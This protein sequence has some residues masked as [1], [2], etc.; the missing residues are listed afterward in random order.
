MFWVVNNMA[1]Q[2]HINVL[3]LLAI[4]F[5]TNVNSSI[6]ETKTHAGSKPHLVMVLQDDLGH[7]DVGFNN[8]Q[9]SSLTP[10]IDN[11]AKSG[12]ILTNHLVHFHCSPTRRSFI[13]GRLP[14]HHGEM[15]SGVATDDVDLRWNLISDKMHS[16]GYECHWIGKGHTGYKSYHHLPTQRGFDSFTGFLAGSQ[17]YTSTDRWQNL[18][19][20]NGSVYSSE[21]FGMETINRIEQR[22]QTKPF[23]LYL[24]WQ[25]VHSPYD[26]VPGWYCNSC[27]KFLPYPGVYAGMLNSSDYYF[28][29]VIQKFKSSN[30]W[31]NMLLVYSSDNG[32]VSENG[33]AGINYP[34]RG[35]KHSNWNGGFRVAAFVS[36]GLIPTNLRG[37]TSN[38]RL[39]IV[40]W[41][42]TFAIMAGVSPRDDPPIKPLPVDPSQPTKDIYGNVSYPGVDGVDVWPF[43][44][45][46]SS[47]IFAA[48][49]NITI[50]AQ[51]I[52]V[53]EYKLLIG[54]GSVGDSGEKTKGK[55]GWRYPNGTWI[56]PPASMTCG[57]AW[58]PQAV[59]DPCLF[60]ESDI[61]EMNDMSKSNPEMVQQLWGLLNLS[62]LTSFHSRSPANLLG[63][64]NTQCATNTW[65]SLGGSGDG[66]VCGVPGCT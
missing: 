30:M 28:G 57:L 42:A 38:F 21:L 52:L 14:I 7:H 18:V 53:N 49:P 1:S 19:P 11:V 59:Y 47:D 48:H 46:N 65:K 12:I 62:V 35:E 45:D 10:N 44:M 58:G 29:Q 25:A 61:R 36:G 33:L 31:D 20:Y 50:S 41:Y 34:L 9:M 13:T 3:L 26:D 8:E 55:D 32:G 2:C 16:A 27:D 40:D 54:Q 51:V 4:S 17:S 63:P 23:F 15:L 5:F 56:S 64:C 39:H 66:P 6:R 43:L 37:T 22:D 24:P 60:V